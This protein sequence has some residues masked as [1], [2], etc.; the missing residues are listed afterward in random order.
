MILLTGGAWQGQEEWIRAHAG[1]E[2]V[3]ADGKT[4][5]PEMVFQAGA[6]LNFQA[7]VRRMVKEG[8][9]EKEILDFAE[10][11][12]RSEPDMILSMDQVGC[13]IVP[14]DP[15]ERRYREMAGKTGQF[16]AAMA[17]E[18]YIITAGIGQRIK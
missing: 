2:A 18:V 14:A 15:F 16:L 5:D 1:E 3:V 10:K 7:W 9:E 4:D 12:A 6:A 11:A 17:D 8:K 13:G